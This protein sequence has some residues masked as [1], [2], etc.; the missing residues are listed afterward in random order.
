MFDS[1]R[2]RTHR[3]LRIAALAITFSFG[4]LGALSRAADGICP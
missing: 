4:A 3:E 1:Y 2:A